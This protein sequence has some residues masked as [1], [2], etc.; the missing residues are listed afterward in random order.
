[1]VFVSQLQKT[2]TEV[3]SR[4]EPRQQGRSREKVQRAVRGI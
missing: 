4:Q 2:G 1:M 3:A